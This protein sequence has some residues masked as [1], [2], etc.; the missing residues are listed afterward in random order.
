[1][2]IYKYTIYYFTLALPLFT[3]YFYLYGC[4]VDIYLCASKECQYSQVCIIIIIHFVLI[5]MYR[6]PDIRDTDSD[7][8]QELPREVQQSN[9]MLSL[10]LR[11]IFILLVCAF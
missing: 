8:S 5:Q 2:Y 9:G 3:T 6:Y 1:M 10:F 7:V 4:F 11:L